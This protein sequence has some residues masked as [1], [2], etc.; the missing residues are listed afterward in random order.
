M[1]ELDV[2]RLWVIVTVVPLTIRSGA[3]YQWDDVVYENRRC[4]NNTVA[5]QASCLVNA[6]VTHCY[7]V[8]ACWCAS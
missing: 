2:G 1:K 4:V 5:A 3:Y 8:R 7:T 6:S